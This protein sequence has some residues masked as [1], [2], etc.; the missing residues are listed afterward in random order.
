MKQ[1]ILEGIKEFVF[2]MFWYVMA[3]IFVIALIG[4]GEWLFS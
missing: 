2:S 4:I 1:E 3:F